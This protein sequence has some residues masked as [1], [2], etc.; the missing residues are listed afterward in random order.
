MVP[1]P[2]RPKRSTRC[3]TAGR[4][5]SASRTSHSRPAR[6]RG[7]K[8]TSV[9][10]ANVLETFQFWKDVVTEIAAGYP[11]VELEHMYVDNAGDAARQGA[12]EV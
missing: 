5:S 9:D 12:E 7:K 11:D 1:L 2:A 3:A 10:K 6:K 8:V 4:R